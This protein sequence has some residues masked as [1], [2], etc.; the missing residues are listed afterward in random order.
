VA[1]TANRPKIVVDENGTQYPNGTGSFAVFQQHYQNLYT[2][3]ISEN[4]DPA[5]IRAS[6]NA[7]VREGSSLAYQLCG[8]FFKTAGTEQ[9]YLLFGRDLIGVAGTLTTGILGLAHAGST[10]VGAVGIGSTAALSGISIYARNFLFS[11]DNVQA[12]QN[13]TLNAMSAAT[14]TALKRTDYDFFT[15]VQAIM[16]VQSVCEVQSILALV[17]QSI[18]QAK[19]QVVPGNN[20]RIAVE[21]PP[22]Q[23]ILQSGLN[24]AAAAAWLRLQDFAQIRT[25]AN[26]LD[27][28]SN[29]SDVG[30]FPL[31]NPAFAAQWVDR[32]D[33]DP[34]H[35]ADVARQLGWNGQ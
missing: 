3:Q 32:N 2:L 1:C 15:A 33:S 20:N 9:Q 13:L 22:Q 12:V 34:R 18:N 29:Y 8:S 7:V 19:P 24:P 23:P 26:N 5:Q 27:N 4:P 6:A 14:A 16:D 11:E 31:A 30:Q 17:R 25:V 21:V 10:A 35:L 28:F